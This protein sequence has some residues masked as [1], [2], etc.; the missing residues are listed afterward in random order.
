MIKE[1]KTEETISHMVKL[2]LIHKILYIHVN[3][4][5]YVF[6]HKWLVEQIVLVM[7]LKKNSLKQSI[8]KNMMSD[9]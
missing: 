6:W 7:K 8:F 1:F 5:T 4:V 3:A 2:L 9:G